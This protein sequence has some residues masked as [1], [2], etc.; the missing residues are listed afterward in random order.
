[1]FII[2]WG[3][4]QPVGEEHLTTPTLPETEGFITDT[5]YVSNDRHLL[6]VPPEAWDKRT[7]IAYTDS[8]KVTM[9]LSS[10]N[11]SGYAQIKLMTVLPIGLK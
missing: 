10:S 2:C 9:Q 8:L 7:G 6:M 4:F 5:I 3:N 1:M 11:A